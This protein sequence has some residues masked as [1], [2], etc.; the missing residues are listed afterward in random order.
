MTKVLAF[1]DSVTLKLMDDLWRCSIV[2]GLLLGRLSVESTVLRLPYRLALQTTRLAVSLING[3]ARHHFVSLLVSAFDY[4]PTN[5][6]KRV[7]N[8]L[9]E[10]RL[11]QIGR[12]VVVFTRVTSIGHQL[13]ITTVLL[14]EAV[15]TWVTHRNLF[16]ICL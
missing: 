5:I 3:A 4:W 6:F 16:A 8:Q 7:R 14:T 12:L 1:I 15:F 2:V 11:F 10:V 9:V 13:I